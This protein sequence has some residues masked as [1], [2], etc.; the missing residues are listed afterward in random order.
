MRR[1]GDTP[2]PQTRLAV[3]LGESTNYVI[4]YINASNEYVLYVYDESLFPIVNSNGEVA[5][6]GGGWEGFINSLIKPRLEESSYGIDTVI[7]EI[8]PRMEVGEMVP[9]WDSYEKL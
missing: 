6:T 7:T 4:G 5:Q 3:R 8:I 2:E 1:G 9:E